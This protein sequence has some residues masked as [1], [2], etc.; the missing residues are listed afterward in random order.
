MRT[1]FMLA[2][3][4][5]VVLVAA[6][7]LLFTVSFVLVATVWG[8]LN[9]RKPSARAQWARFQQSA[10]SSVWQRYR[11]QASGSARAP[12]AHRPVRDVEDI[13]YRE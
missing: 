1:V 8:L 2:L 5:L 6:V 3:G 7:L 11:S 13:A 9:G 4:V 12:Q 10:A